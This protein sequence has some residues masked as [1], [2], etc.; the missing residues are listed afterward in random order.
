MNYEGIGI[1]DH[2]KYHLVICAIA[3]ENH[4]AINR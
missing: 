1:H 4:H 2:S 3:M